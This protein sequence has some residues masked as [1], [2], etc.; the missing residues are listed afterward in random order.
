MHTAAP[1]V[2]GLAAYYRSVS[3]PWKQQ[4]TSPAHVKKLIR[5]FHRRFNVN[6][7]KEHGANDR[8]KQRPIIWN[9]Q[10][11]DR[12]CLKDYAV[13][14]VRTDWSKKNCPDIELDLNNQSDNGET[15]RPCTGPSPRAR[16]ADGGSCPL[17]PDAPSSGGDG[18]EAY[19][20]S[21]TSGPAP[22]PT[23][24]SGS[25]C[26]GKVCTGFFC[27]PNPTGVPPDRHDPKDPNGGSRVPTQTILP[28]PGPT[29]PPNECNDQCKLDRGNACGRGETGCSANSPAC[30]RNGSCPTCH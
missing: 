13:N 26:G 16:Q 15:V 20:V 2:A 5:K 21:F 19:T 23:C 29:D 18:G 27:T 6:P 9:G 8:K 28:A 17:L 7:P 12:S 10:Y 11:K 30:Y 24:A 3:S 4:L 22:S 14:V 25:G 1:Q